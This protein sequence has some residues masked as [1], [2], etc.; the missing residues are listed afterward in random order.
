MLYEVITLGALGQSIQ[1]LQVAGIDL[2]ILDRFY[3]RN[4]LEKVLEP[5]GVQGHKRGIETDWA[6][7]RT[8]PIA[9]PNWAPS[10]IT[11][12][13]IHYTKLYERRRILVQDGAQRRCDALVRDGVEGAPN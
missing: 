2:C 10:V 11:S 8:M 12:Y 7:N 9:P 5:G 3:E 1:P 4:R 6:R 13:S